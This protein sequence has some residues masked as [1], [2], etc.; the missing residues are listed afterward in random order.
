[1]ALD[2]IDNKLK[3]GNVFTEDKILGEISKMVGEFYNK[4]L[5]EK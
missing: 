1:M 5:K 4:N 3:K 2:F